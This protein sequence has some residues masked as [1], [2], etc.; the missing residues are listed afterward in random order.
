MAYVHNKKD[1]PISVVNHIVKPHST[2]YI[3]IPKGMVSN[4][5][6]T[7]TYDGLEKPAETVVIE[8]DTRTTAQKRGRK[9]KQNIEESE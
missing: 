1:F 5:N 3:D 7:I 4:K 8:K 2:V 9:S 6:V